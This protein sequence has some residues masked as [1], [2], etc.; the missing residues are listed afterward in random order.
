MT[1]SD[2]PVTY[3]FGRTDPPYSPTA[4]H[5]GDDHAMP[6]GTQVIVNGTLIGLSGA[7][8]DVT[9]PHLHVGHYV[10]AKAVN[11]NGGGFDL[12]S[13]VTVYDTNQDSMNGKYVRLLDGS[14]TIWL[15]DHL[16]KN[17]IVTK[18]QAIGGDMPTIVDQ[19]IL[20][21][22]TSAICNSQP[23]E[24]DKSLIGVDMVKATTILYEDKRHKDLIAQADKANASQS[25]NVVPYSGPQLFVEK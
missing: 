18:G 23:I 15:Y 20:S 22:L 1:A 17:D 4:P 12:P 25:S 8:G 16:S 24:S 11:P 9:G 3:G 13:P 7:T 21:L 5:Q 10:N 6:T 2:Y 14:G 19:N